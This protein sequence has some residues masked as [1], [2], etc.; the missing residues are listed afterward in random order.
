MNFIKASIL[1]L[2]LTKS[3]GLLGQSCPLKIQLV[4]DTVACRFEF[5]PPRGSSLPKQFNVTLQVIAGTPV[6]INWSNGATGSVLKPDSTGTFEAIVTDISGCKA[7]AKVLVREYGNP[8]S[9]NSDFQFNGACLGDTTEFVGTTTSTIDRYQWTF[10]DG[11]GSTFSKPKKYYSTAGT[12]SV[13]LRLTNRCGLDNS[14]VKEVKIN[15]PPPKPT[16]PPAVSLCSAIVLDANSGNISQIVSYLWSTGSTTKTIVVSEPSIISVKNMD[17]NGCTSTAT[18]LVVENR[19]IVDLGPSVSICQY[20]S[21]PSLNAFNAGANFAWKLNGILNVN[22]FSTQTIDTT[23]PGI[24]VYSVTVTD[25]ITLCFRQAEKQITVVS[26]PTTA[27]VPSAGSIC[28]DVVI[29]DANPTNEANLSYGWST[30]E[31]TKTIQV[32]TASSISVVK[33]NTITGCSSSASI[34]ISDSRPKVTLGS[35]QTICQFSSAFL[36]AQNA[37]LRFEW[38]VNGLPIG[39]TSNI[40]PIN[41]SSTGNFDYSVKVTDPTTNCSQVAGAVITI[42]QSPEKPI[43]TLQGHSILRSSNSIGNQWFKNGNLLSGETNQNLVVTESGN[44]FV[45][46]RLNNC[47]STSENFVFTITGLENPTVKSIEFSVFP[48]PVNDWLRVEFDSGNTFTISVCDLSGRVLL[49]RK[50][51][52]GSFIQLEDIADGI[53]LIKLEDSSRVYS[54]RFVKR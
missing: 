40:Q 52:T 32:S 38:K 20:S 34:A 9:S 31:T 42:L 21:Q 51:Q 3:F 50:I 4:K 36:N 14:I 24:F 37:G 19:P 22:N 48:N 17:L 29:L 39:N 23:V 25:P 7:S 27:L 11:S 10:G 43:I 33:T 54:T 45:Q 49:R 13:L 53:Y 26:A 47:L 16:I 28:T 1:I 18:S 5:P 15:P 44:Y 12:Y 41:S 6:S 35:A 30:G 8:N 46:T 2:S